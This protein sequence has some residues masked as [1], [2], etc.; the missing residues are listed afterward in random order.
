MSLPCV[1]HIDNYE[2]FRA[3]MF[4]CEKRNYRWAAGELPT[5]FNPSW[6]HHASGNINISWDGY[7]THSCV[8]LND[9]LRY[10]TCEVFLADEFI[11]GGTIEN[12][13]NNLSLEEVLML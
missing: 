6:I 7:L 13:N 2:E 5:Q 8:P 3:V 10:E 4:E 11:F 9:L 1:V 12:F